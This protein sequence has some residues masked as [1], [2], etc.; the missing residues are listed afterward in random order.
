MY[1]HMLATRA[2]RHELRDISRA[3]ARSSSPTAPEFSFLRSDC[4]PKLS[5][6]R[7]ALTELT[8]IFT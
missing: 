5:E 2:Q 7:A 8:Q 3:V 1:Q 4:G 6:G